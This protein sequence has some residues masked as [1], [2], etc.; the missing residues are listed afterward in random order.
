MADREE[1]EFQRRNE[2]YWRN[3]EFLKEDLCHELESINTG[4]RILI[5]HTKY[6]QLNPYPEY[7]PRYPDLHPGLSVLEDN[8]NRLLLT[9]EDIQKHVECPVKK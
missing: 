9:I 3:R 5:Q 4:L 1:E 8:F 6:A 7:P 2:E